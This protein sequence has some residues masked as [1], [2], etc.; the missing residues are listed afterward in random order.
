MHPVLWIW[1]HSFNTSCQILKEKNQLPYQTKNEI[2]FRLPEQEIFYIIYSRKYDRRR[3]LVR[4]CISRVNIYLSLLLL[5]V[6]LTDTAELFYTEHLS[7]GVTEWKEDKKN[8]KNITW[9]LFVLWHQKCTVIVRGM[10]LQIGTLHT[11]R[12]VRTFY[13]CAW[14]YWILGRRRCR[15]TAS[16][17][18]FGTSTDKI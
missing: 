11:L 3:R 10:E 12:D 6:L 1:R 7:A 18:V 17:F 5:P 13:S 9:K 4:A 14:V 16:Y 8:V 15:R 2:K